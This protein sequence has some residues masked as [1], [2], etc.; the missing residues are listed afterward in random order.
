MFYVIFNVLQP[1]KYLILKSFYHLDDDVRVGGERMVFIVQGDVVKHRVFQET[2]IGDELE[3]DRK[4][5]SQTKNRK[6][7]R[8]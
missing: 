1:L 5:D 2:S 3:T 7:D 4:T 6:T 8:Q